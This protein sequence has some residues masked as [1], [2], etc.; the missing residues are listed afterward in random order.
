MMRTMYKFPMLPAACYEGE[1]AYGTIRGRQ[2]PLIPGYD[3]VLR[4]FYGDYTRP[5]EDKS[6]FIQHLD[7]EDQVEIDREAWDATYGLAGAQ[8]Q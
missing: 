1:P 4:F 6:A 5:P 2:F 7:E 8:R 3:H